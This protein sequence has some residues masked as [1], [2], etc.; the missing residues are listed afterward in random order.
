MRQPQNACILETRQDIN[1]SSTSLESAANF[2]SYRCGFV[3][4]LNFLKNNIC[5]IA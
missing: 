4:L 5:K 2:T 3:I 1:I